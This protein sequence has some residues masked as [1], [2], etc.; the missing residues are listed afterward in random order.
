MRHPFTPDNE[1]VPSEADL[2][3][4]EKTA[5]WHIVNPLTEE[6]GYCEPS[7]YELP[8]VGRVFVHGV[9]DYTLCDWYARSTVLSCGTMTGVTSGGA[10][11]QPLF[12]QLRK[13]GVQ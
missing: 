6:W 5:F 2:V 7:G 9:V 8:Y 12:G 1:P 13:G 3:A 11:L 10:R 4:C